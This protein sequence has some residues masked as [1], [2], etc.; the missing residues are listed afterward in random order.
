MS[1][2]KREI[3]FNSIYVTCVD[4]WVSDS[5]YFFGI[6][7]DSAEEGEI[8]SINENPW[9]NPSVWIEMVDEFKSIFP[10]WDTRERPAEMYLMCQVF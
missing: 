4:S 9:I 1:D 3:F 5:E 6:Y 10:E 8:M 7:L 2:D